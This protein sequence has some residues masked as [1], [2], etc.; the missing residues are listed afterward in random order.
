VI[1]IEE[2]T[3]LEEKKKKRANHGLY[4]K[5]TESE[6]LGMGPSSLFYRTF[7]V[8]LMCPKAMSH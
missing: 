6:T 2:Y 4:P 7:Q 3:Y 8:I 5:P 1:G